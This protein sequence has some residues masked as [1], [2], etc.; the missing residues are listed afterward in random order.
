M[1]EEELEQI[2][3]LIKADGDSRDKTLQDT[4]SGVMTRLMKEPGGKDKQ[5]GDRLTKIEKGLDAITKSTNSDAF[6]TIIRQQIDAAFEEL[7]TSEEEELSK[8]PERET[9]NQKA[10]D[11]QKTA[12]S[13]ENKAIAELKKQI[14]KNAEAYQAQVETLQAALTQET[15]TREKLAEQARVNGMQEDL[16]KGLRGKVTP[17]TEAQMFILMKEEGLLVEE[18]ET[19]RYLVKMTEPTGLSSNMTIDK[20]LPKLLQDKYPFFNPKRD[21]T[22]TGGTGGTD[23][24]KTNGSGGKIFQGGDRQ[25]TDAELVKIMNDPKQV[26][27]AM[28]EL[29]RL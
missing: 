20:A 13:Q 11:Q 26:E 14:A 15:S 21:G 28:Q 8:T 24:S 2:R 18:P 17:A 22:G 23:A 12:N 1:T 9:E 27:S 4:I 25:P 29:N 16:M 5:L 7:A 6:S 3:E 19:N 10:P